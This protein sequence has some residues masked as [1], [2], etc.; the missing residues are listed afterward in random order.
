MQVKKL[1]FSNQITEICKKTYEE[2]NNH[3]IIQSLIKMT[4]SIFQLE[5]IFPSYF[6][7]LLTNLLNLLLTMHM[8]LFFPFHCNNLLLIMDDF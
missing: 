4:N 3:L 7:K 2:M 8:N 6:V 5:I 1:I